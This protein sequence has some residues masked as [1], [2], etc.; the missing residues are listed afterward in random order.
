MP[1]LTFGF[2]RL[3]VKWEAGGF[4]DLGRES[5]T[6]TSN[7]KENLG[8]LFWTKLEEI[9]TASETKH[10]KTSPKSAVCFNIR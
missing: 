1:V 7:V 6:T 5:K 3:K 10:W 4:K 9:G 8:S 2:S